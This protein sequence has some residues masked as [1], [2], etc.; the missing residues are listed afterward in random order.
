MEGRA[1]VDRCINP[2]P[3][4]VA[5]DDALHDRQTNACAFE[6]IVAVEPLED[7][8]E[9]V[10]VFHVEYRAVVP[11]EVHGFFRFLSCP[12]FDDANFSAS[13]ELERIGQQIH[14]H[15]LE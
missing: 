1:L 4:A 13:C 6:L 2:D 9:S 15:L 5:L 3:A 14:D 11:N 12:H 8:E 7:V 10:G